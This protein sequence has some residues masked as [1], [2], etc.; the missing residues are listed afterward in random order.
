VKVSALDR[1]AWACLFAFAIEKTA[2][3]VD[4]G[5]ALVT[6]LTDHRP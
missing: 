6:E 4:H 3:K 2:F 1:N 5:R